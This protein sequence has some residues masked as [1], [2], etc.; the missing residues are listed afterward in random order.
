MTGTRMPFVNQ[1]QIIAT[2]WYHI[3]G[4][5]MFEIGNITLDIGTNQFFGRLDAHRCDFGQIGGKVLGIREGDEI[6]IK[7]LFGRVH[8]ENVL[9]N[10]G[11]AGQCH[12]QNGQSFAIFIIATSL[13]ELDECLPGAIGI[14]AIAIPTLME[15]DMKFNDTTLLNRDSSIQYLCSDGQTDFDAH[16]IGFGPDKHGIFQLHFGTGGIRSEGWNVFQQNGHQFRTFQIDRDV[17]AASII[18]FE[19]TALT[20]LMNDN[21]GRTT[22]TTLQQPSQIHLLRQ[23]R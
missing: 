16:R 11:I 8:T 17:F 23:T 14:F 18:A 6:K 13:T 9:A 19:S 21:V 7:S 10:G 15:F 4:N 22:W 20:T 1:Y 2:E 3:T 5:G 12:F